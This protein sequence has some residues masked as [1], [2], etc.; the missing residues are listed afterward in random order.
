MGQ[1]NQGDGPK[2]QQISARLSLHVSQSFLKVCD[3]NCQTLANPA[4]PYLYIPYNYSCIYL[5]IGSRMQA[6]VL[7]R[8]SILGT[9]ALATRIVFCDRLPITCLT[10]TLSSTLRYNDN[11]HKYTPHIIART[12]PHTKRERGQYLNA[13]FLAWD[14]SVSPCDFELSSQKV[15]TKSVGL[16]KFESNWAV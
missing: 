14:A 4:P 2:N 6:T 12:H 16:A 15:L 10:K 3:K 11:T 13:K 5:F 8:S 1:P 9:L 7:G